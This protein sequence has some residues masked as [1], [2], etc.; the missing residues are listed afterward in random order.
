M[1]RTIFWIAFSCS[2]GL[3]AAGEAAEN[4]SPDKAIL[5]LQRAVEFFRTKVS[6]EGGYLWRYAS[7]FS[8]REGELPASLSTVWVQPPGTPLVG[9]A[10]LRSYELTGIRECLEA[11]RKTAMALVR[12]QL[13]SGG[14]D[15]RIEFSAEVRKQY[16]YRADSTARSKRRNVTTL[17]DN[18][19]QAALSF[20]MRI[21]QALDFKDESIHE[22]AQ[23]AL[24]K[25]L[26]AQYPNGAWPQRF[27]IPPDPQ[28]FPVKPAD[29]PVTWLREYP[30]Q[31]YHTYYTFNDNTMVDVI[32]MMFLA[33]E[34]YGYKKYAEAGQA[35]G[36]F[37]L[38]AQMPEP[39]P[40]W[41]QQYNAQM[42]PAW[43]RK[44]EPPSITGSESQRVMKTLLRLF[45][46]TRDQKFLEPLPRAL[47]YFR[48]SQLKDGQLARFYELETNRPL[49]FTKDYRM[50]YSDTDL[51]THYGFK[52]QNQLDEIETKFQQLIATAD[53]EVSPVRVSPEQKPQ[54][55]TKNLIDT[56][57]KLVQT[58]D[59]RGAWVEPAYFRARSKMPAGASSISCRTFA[60][61][62]MALAQY[63]AATSVD[64]P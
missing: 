19:T 57:A 30:Q 50:T 62:I 20:L 2:V 24:G 16:A 22:A 55:L 33:A 40:G 32:D 52:S 63:I 38:L 56:A 4:I 8:E 17:D 25:L 5:A 58:Q 54:R 51:P 41:A 31:A 6:V 36:R 35:G 14:W 48:S 42:H 11:A 53:S 45:E 18:T 23:Y 10:Y 9:M 7:D 12:G 37:I 47:A 29:Y 64:K 49:Y 43:A 39:Q 15:Y 13:E 28:E 44:F 61:N 46:L 59:A 3:P 21:D 27:S 26:A 34:I 60:T 1:V